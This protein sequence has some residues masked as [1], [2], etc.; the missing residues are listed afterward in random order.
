MTELAKAYMAKHPSES[1]TV[2]QESMS[3][4]GGIEGTKI[5][6]VNIGLVT[7]EPKGPDR[8][9]L[10]YKALGR[11][12]AGVALHRSVPV[13]GL[14]EAQVCDIFSGKITSLKEVDGN[15]AR[16]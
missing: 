10:V 5:G 4:T 7:D 12:P 1:I 2:L 6:R 14:S 13:N 15:D 3:N 8:E 9:K 16:S 11:T